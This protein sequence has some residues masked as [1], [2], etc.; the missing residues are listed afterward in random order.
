MALTITQR[1]RIPLS[2]GNALYVATV[3]GDGAATTITAAQVGFVRFNIAFLVNN[4]EA[5]FTPLTAAGSYGTTLTKTDAFESAKTVTLI[6]IG[7]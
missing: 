1:V 3:L 6:A 5:T 4:D 7:Y 2:D